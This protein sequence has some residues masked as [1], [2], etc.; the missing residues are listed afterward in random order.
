MIPKLID[1]VFNLLIVDI[2]QFGTILTKNLLK[3]SATA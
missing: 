1:S 2:F 3:T